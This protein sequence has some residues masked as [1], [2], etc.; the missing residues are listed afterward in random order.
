MRD[1]PGY[2]KEAGAG[3]GAGVAEAGPPVRTRTVAKNHT[4]RK[5]WK[6]D[7]WHGTHFGPRQR[8]QRRR[9]GGLGE[10]KA[11]ARVR[12]AYREGSKAGQ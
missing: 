1:S 5:N 3:A 11:R 8:S 4:S 12:A 9:K 7:P 2:R 10:G 6:K